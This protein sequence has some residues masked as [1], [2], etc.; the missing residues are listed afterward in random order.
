MFIQCTADSMMRL[1][2]KC[3]RVVDLYKNS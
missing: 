3:Y 1:C 2:C